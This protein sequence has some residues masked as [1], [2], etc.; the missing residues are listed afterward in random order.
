MGYL[1]SKLLKPMCSVHACLFEKLSSREILSPNVRCPMALAGYLFDRS[2]GR[3]LASYLKN[4]PSLS[5][6][7]LSQYNVSLYIM[8][9]SI[10]CLS[11]LNNA[12]LYTLKPTHSL[13]H[14]LRSWLHEISALIM[15][16]SPGFEKPHTLERSSNSFPGT[17]VCQGAWKT[18]RNT[19]QSPIVLQSRGQHLFSS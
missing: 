18:V 15:T 16:L 7:C 9:L 2:F 19:F 12:S 10:Q 17:E 8:P 14:T 6:Q 13:C 11:L 4:T 1:H 5:I 3:L